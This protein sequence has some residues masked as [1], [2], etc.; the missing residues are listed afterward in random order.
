[1][2]KPQKPLIG[3][4]SYAIVCANCHQ[5]V[6]RSAQFL[7]DDYF[8]KGCCCPRCDCT[9]AHKKVG[10][11]YG[12]HSSDWE[13]IAPLFYE[14]HPVMKDEDGWLSMFLFGGTWR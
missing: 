5:Q 8:G 6:G 14:L 13:W 3:I 4:R 10:R 12:P 9:S 1:M 7:I 2:D 11:V